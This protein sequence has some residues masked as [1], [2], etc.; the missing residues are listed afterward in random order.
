[1]KEIIGNCARL[2]LIPEHARQKQQP[3]DTEQETCQ[4]FE[5]FSKL[6]SSEDSS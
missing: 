6:Q 4:L 1:M 5:A 3:L 2:E